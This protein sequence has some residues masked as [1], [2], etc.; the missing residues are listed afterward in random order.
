MREFSHPPTPGAR[1][2]IASLGR[3]NDRED[4]ELHRK[5]WRDLSARVETIE[6][7]GLIAE[8]HAENGY[9]TLYATRRSTKV[10]RG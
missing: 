9:F 4:I 7:C 8:L 5:A 1:R 2:E 6:K 3:P 10:R